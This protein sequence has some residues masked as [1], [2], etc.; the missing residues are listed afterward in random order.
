[1]LPAAHG[2]EN[3][4]V[5]VAVHVMYQEDRGCTENFPVITGCEDILNYSPGLNH[6]PDVFPVFFDIVE[7]KRLDYAVNFTDGGWSVVFHSCSDN[8]VI[9]ESQQ[10]FWEISQTYTECQPGPVAIPGWFVLWFEQGWACI[11][12]HPASSM[13][14]IGDCQDPM[15]IDSPPC[16][17][18]SGVGHVYDCTDPCDPCQPS[19]NQRSTLGEVKAMFR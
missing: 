4:D 12:E 13:I 9:D 18:C 1:M 16:S 14:K 17:F 8:A 2:G 6:N 19:E 15:G 10:G 5:K 7:Y 3:P 11:V